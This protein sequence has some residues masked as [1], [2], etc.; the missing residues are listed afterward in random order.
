MQE[1]ICQKWFFGQS[2][3]EVWEW[4][5]KPGGHTINGRRFNSKVVWN[6]LPKDHGTELQIQHGG[7]I[8]SEGVLNHSSGWNT[9][10]K[11]FEEFINEIKK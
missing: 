4:L 8:E 9:S 5:M 6:V 3:N 7:F 10:L 1:N 2:T 11:R